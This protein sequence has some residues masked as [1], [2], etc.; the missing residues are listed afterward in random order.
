MNFAFTHEAYNS[1]QYV[2]AYS[3]LIHKK[4]QLY[5]WENFLLGQ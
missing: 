4:E 5:R 2:I 3:N 1:M